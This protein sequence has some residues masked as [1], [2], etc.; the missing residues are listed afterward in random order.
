VPP[1]QVWTGAENL[2]FTGIQSPDRPARSESLYQ[3]CYFGPLALSCR[4]PVFR[5][6]NNILI[7]IQHLYDIQVIK[8]TEVKP[9]LIVLTHVKWH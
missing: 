1:G 9:F 3:L 6:P 2:A 7:I 5:H 4:N 8:H